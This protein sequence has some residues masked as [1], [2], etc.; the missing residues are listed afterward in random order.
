MGA[1][2]LIAQFQHNIQHHAQGT[3]MAG[4][5]RSP[6]SVTLAAPGINPKQRVS[7]SYQGA[8]HDGSLSVATLMAQKPTTKEDLGRATWT[9]LHT[10]AAQF[11][12]KPTKQQQRDARTLIDCLTR[13]YP[14]ADCAKHFQHIVR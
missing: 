8:N 6:A 1:G 2:A 10:M 7:T 13:V 14:C 9:F 12:A 11:P 4:H 5:N 3:R